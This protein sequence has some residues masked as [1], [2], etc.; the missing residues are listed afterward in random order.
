MKKIWLF[1]LCLASLG[2]V[3]CFHVPDEDWL[4]SKNK[5]D[6]W[7]VQKDTWMQQAVDSLIEWINIISSQR[8]E[9]KNEENNEES[10][11]I[12]GSGDKNIDIEE[13]IEDEEAV[14]NRE[15]INTW[16]DNQEI[17]NAIE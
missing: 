9:M 10:G 17:E 7:N 15:V 14:N 5:I 2:L 6:T 3:G 11:E 16:N 12:A 8:D 13:I 4:P 1:C